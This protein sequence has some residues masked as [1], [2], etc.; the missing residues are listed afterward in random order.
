MECGRR[1]GSQQVPTVTKVDEVTFLLVYCEHTSRLRTECGAAGI[2]HR[3]QTI[4]AFRHVVVPRVLVGIVL[5]HATGPASQHGVGGVVAT[6]YIALVTRG[7]R[8]TVC[9]N[10]W[11]LPVSRVLLLSLGLVHIR[12][13]D[14]IGVII[15]KLGDIQRGIGFG[16]IQYIGTVVLRIH[17]HS[18][19]AAVT[20]LT[21]AGVTCGF[22]PIR[23][24]PITPTST[25]PTT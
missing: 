15:V 6:L 13:L 9:K 22:F 19:I 25:R 2:A 3:Q 11:V 21:P 12:G 17:E 1:Y 4:R 23:A 5:F 16:R 14:Y 8:S 24:M 18:H 7:I 20:V 10:V